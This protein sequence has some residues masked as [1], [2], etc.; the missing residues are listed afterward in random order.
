MSTIDELAARSGAALRHDVVH[1]LDLEASLSDLRARRRRHRLTRVAAAVTASAAAVA[2]AAAVIVTRDAG[3]TEPSPAPAPAR[4]LLPFVCEDGHSVHCLGG[5]RVRV[6]R[7]QPFTLTPPDGYPEIDVG[8]KGTELF[9]SD[10]VLG[11]GVVFFDDVVPARTGQH[12]SARQLAYWVAA[13]PYLDPRPGAATTITPSRT[14]VDGR[15]A[16]E[17]QVTTGRA[18][19]SPATGCNG[20]AQLTCWALLGTLREGT[21]PWETGPWQSAANHYTFVD[22]PDGAT[23][24]IWSVAFGGDWAAIDANEELIGTLHFVGH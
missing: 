10:T 14:T 6:D 22:L 23:F 4:P 3:T 5:G 16:W 12:L 20:S 7:P 11:A 24:V 21:G 17:V 15:P 18:P 19:D 13:R 1:T 9:R 2:I 8:E